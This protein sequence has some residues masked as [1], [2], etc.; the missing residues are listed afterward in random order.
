MDDLKNELVRK[1]SEI[2]GLR[3][4]EKERSDK[5]AELMAENQRLKD[6][7]SKMEKEAGEFE[8]RVESVK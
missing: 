6:L 4:A 1:E 2:D 5:L 3:N 8:Q 7:M